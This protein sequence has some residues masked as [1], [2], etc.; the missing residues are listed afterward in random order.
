M[1]SLEAYVAPH[2]AVH[3][4]VDGFPGAK[5]H[6]V[7]KPGILGS[8]AAKRYIAPRRAVRHV[9]GAE[10]DWRRIGEG[11]VDKDACALVRLPGVHGEVHVEDG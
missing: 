7:F 4:A 3:V 2:E 5:F 10:T 11:G 1:R 9:V 6:A 8:D